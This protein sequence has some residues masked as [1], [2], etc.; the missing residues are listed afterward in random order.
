MKPILPLQSLEHGNAEQVSEL[1][2]APDLLVGFD[3]EEDGNQRK[4]NSS[5]FLERGEPTKNVQTWYHRSFI[6]WICFEIHSL[7]NFRY[8]YDS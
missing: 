7:E 1:K 2:R 4:Y 8:A 3:F 6:D 5:A